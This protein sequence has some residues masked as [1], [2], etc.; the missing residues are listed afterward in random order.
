MTLNLT[1]RSFTAAAS[2]LPL[3]S[4]TRLFGAAATHV[5]SPTP[6]NCKNP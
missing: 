4:G 6:T 2:L 1:R 3:A 5:P